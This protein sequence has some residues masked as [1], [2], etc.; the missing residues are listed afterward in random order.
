VDYTSFFSPLLDSSSNSLSLI[1]L[2]ITFPENS[3][4]N[5]YNQYL[6]RTNLI[7]KRGSEEGVPGRG[8]TKDL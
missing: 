7:L 2:K 6:P 3:Y 4:Y 8:K 5:L 1:V